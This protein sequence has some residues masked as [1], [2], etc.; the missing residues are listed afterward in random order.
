M[1][2]ALERA[3]LTLIR[4]LTDKLREEP[5]ALTDGFVLSEFLDRVS[6]RLFTDRTI[7]IVGRD[8]FVPGERL[9][10]WLAG[11]IIIIAGFVVFWSLRAGARERASV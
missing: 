9:T 1:L 4:E 6:N 10:L 3:Y 2:P 11:T 7:T 5:D 8:L